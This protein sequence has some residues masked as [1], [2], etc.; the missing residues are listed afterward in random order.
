[1]AKRGGCE[2]LAKQSRIDVTVKP[3]S[4]RRDRRRGFAEIMLPG[5]LLKV[6]DIDEAASQMCRA[7]AYFMTQRHN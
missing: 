3:N 6:L 7:N 2:N 4:G 5:F 1:M